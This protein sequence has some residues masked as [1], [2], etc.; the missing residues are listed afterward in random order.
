MSTVRR[1]D[2]IIEGAPIAVMSAV[3]QTPPVSF[4]LRVWGPLR[5]FDVPAG[6]APSSAGIAS[7][8]VCPVLL[9][10]YT[11]A[12]LMRVMQWTARTR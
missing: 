12:R 2:A 4:W 9:Q 10:R 8:N 5:P 6:P 11:R 3:L 1:F 7:A